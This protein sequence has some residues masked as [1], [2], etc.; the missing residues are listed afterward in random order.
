MHIPQETILAIQEATQVEEVLSEF[1]SLQKKGKKYLCPF[2]PEKSPSF[3]ISPDGKFFKCF[4]CD[5]K[6]N[7]ISFLMEQ[8]GM[9]YL[10]SMQ[11]LAKKYGI[12][13]EYKEANEEELEAK[14]KNEALYILLEQVKDYY[15]GNLSSS[16]AY[17]HLK[18]RHLIDTTVLQKFSIGYSLPEWHALHDFFLSQ[19]YNEEIL[20]EGGLLATK[21]RKGEEEKRYD[22]FRDRLMFT[23]HSTSGRVIGFAGR[24]LEDKAT[25]PKYINSPETPIYQKGKV[26]YGLY[27]GKKGIKA[28]NNCYLVEGYT[29]VLALHMIGINNVV[30]SGGTSLTA[31]QVALIK[32]F[33]SHIT[34]LF[35]GDHAGQQAALRSTD[36]LLSTGMD[37]SVVSLPPTEDPESYRRKE[38]EKAFKD[39][40]A[41]HKEDLITFIGNK[42][43]Q[44]A[45]ENP[46]QRARAATALIKIIAT[47][48][49]PLKRTLYIQASS[50]LLALSEKLLEQQLAGILHHKKASPKRE[51][52]SKE[53]TKEETAHLEHTLLYMLLR[54]GTYTMTT[55]DKLADYLRQELSNIPFSHPLYQSLW[56]HFYTAWEKE[57]PFSPEEFLE[58]QEAHIADTGQKI[59]AKPVQPS[60]AWEE[61]Y[62]IRIRTEEEDL[63]VHVIK[64]V[65]RM[66]LAWLKKELAKNYADFQRATTAEERATHLT[67]YDR[68]KAAQVEI[69]QSLGIIILP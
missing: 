16:P 43:L 66:K 25:T 49:D 15:I 3:S 19:G 61:R 4:G 37:V 54:Y 21:R 10:H 27:Q 32:R 64:N 42:L 45:G 34:L 7:A 28:E 36:S 9:S 2:H 8:Q 38:G 13:W 67:T 51:P 1:L 24:S 23:L 60:T 17:A 50:K 30:A 5:A 41:S 59:L 56:H 33:T 22:L 63:T 48:P 58:R 55:G 46:S 14:K 44:E 39:Y 68:L 65:K 26:L 29:D 6:G 40:L 31:S 35:D 62:H 47:I 18:K 12:A 11:Y 52:T 53:E 57:E 20:L 69:A